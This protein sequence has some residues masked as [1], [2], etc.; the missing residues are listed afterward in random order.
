MKKYTIG[1]Y[2]VLRST[3]DLNL[4]AKKLEDDGYQVYANDGQRAREHVKQAANQSIVAS[5]FAVIGIDE[6]GDVI[7]GPY[8]VVMRPHSKTYF[9]GIRPKERPLIG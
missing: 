9:G 6:D 1:D 3:A 4:A 2:F 5:G 8:S 7:I